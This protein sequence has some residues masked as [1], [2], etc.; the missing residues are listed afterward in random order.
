ML[1]LIR[2]AGDIA[3]GIAW[4]LW[5]AQ[6]N[7]VMTD[8]PQPTAIRRTVAFSTALEQ[9]HMTIEGVD[10]IACTDLRDVQRALN[11]RKIAVLPDPTLSQALQISPD[12]VIDAI[13]AKRN[14]GTTIQMAPLVIGIGPGFC[15]GQDCH[16][17]IETQRGHRLG[18]VISQGCAAPNSGIPGNI[19]GYTTQRILRAPCDGIFRSHTS[20]GAL[21]K[22]GQVV[23]EVSGTPVICEIDGMI[24][25]MLADNIPVTSGFKCGDV[26]PRGSDA[27]FDTISDKA[28]AVAGGVLEAVLRVHGGSLA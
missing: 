24:R 19:S 2:G 1:V 14:L 7:I 20:I 23:A 6:Q 25:G 21:V 18:R 5:H 17:V 15:A 11:N 9:G 27:E 22:A 12:I 3:S 13:L 10:A 16:Y 8:L 28:R 26:D 4:R